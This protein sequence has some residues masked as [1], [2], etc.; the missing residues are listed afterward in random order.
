MG[1]WGLEIREIICAWT[2]A[3][4]HSVCAQGNVTD[5]LAVR[6]RHIHSAHPSFGTVQNWVQ[7]GRKQKNAWNKPQKWQ[8]LLH[9]AS[10]E[11]GRACIFKTHIFKI[12]L[13]RP[14]S[15]LLGD[16]SPDNSDA[17]SG[18]EPHFGLCF[19]S[20]VFT[21]SGTL[22]LSFYKSFHG[23]CMQLILLFWRKSS[24][25]SLSPEEVKTSWVTENSVKVYWQHKNYIRGG[26]HQT[27]HGVMLSQ[28][29]TQ[30]MV[31]LQFF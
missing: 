17:H 30:N 9:G 4:G 25:L 1:L 28:Y 11:V 12:C 10:T 31:L 8:L 15:Y 24:H 29:F 18:N 22:P 3:V 27:T 23:C 2:Y 6:V 20:T 7:T 5:I 14:H 13:F 16:A 19:C 26:N 21:F